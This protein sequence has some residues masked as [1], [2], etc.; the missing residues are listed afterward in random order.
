LK[1]EISNRGTTVSAQSYRSGT[2]QGWIREVKDHLRGSIVR[3][4]EL[5]IDRDAP[6]AA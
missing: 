3:H 2:E 6:G 1:R 5:A 4:D